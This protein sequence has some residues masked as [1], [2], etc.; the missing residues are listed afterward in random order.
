M[1][2][3]T[4]WLEKVAI[5]LARAVRQGK[6]G[7]PIKLGVKFDS[8]KRNLSKWLKAEQTREMMNTFPELKTAVEN[9]V[10]P[11]RLFH[12]SG[13]T[14]QELISAGNQD[15]AIRVFQTVSL[16]ND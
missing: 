6:T 14:I 10:E 8:D 3:Q 15:E 16:A 9:L 7:E 11:H 13:R 4:A 12:E 2:E 1:G 5:K